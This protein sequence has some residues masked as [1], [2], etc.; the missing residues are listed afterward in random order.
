M[1]VIRSV[2]VEGVVSVVMDETVVTLLIVEVETRVRMI[3]CV[4]VVVDTWGA[5]LSQSSDRRHKTGAQP[6]SCPN[7]LTLR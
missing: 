7:K 5:C 3:D 2:V 6:V 1:S 4:S